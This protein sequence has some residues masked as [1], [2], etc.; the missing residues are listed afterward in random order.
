MTEE[1]AVK[2]GWQPG[3]IQTMCPFHRAMFEEVATPEARETLARL[4]GTR[5]W[6]RPAHGVLHPDEDDDT[7]VTNNECLPLQVKTHLNSTLSAGCFSCE[8]ATD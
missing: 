3:I 5:V 1:E 8:V 4:L 6:V 7:S 2:A